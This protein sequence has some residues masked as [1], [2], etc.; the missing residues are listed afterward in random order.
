MTLTPPAESPAPEG[1]QERVEFLEIMDRLDALD[2]AMTALGQRM[3]AL[4]GSLATAVGDEVRLAAGELRHT[5][6]ELGRRLALDLPQILTRHRDAIL[7]QLPAAARQSP[8]SPDSFDSPD[9]DDS[10]EA[11]VAG[12]DDAAGLDEPTLVVAVPEDATSTPEESGQPSE[13]RRK[14]LLRRRGA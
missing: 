2:E 5:V 4:E 10:A 11:V 1:P 8:V 14:A 7:A 12:A 13:R 3:T 6:A 9:S